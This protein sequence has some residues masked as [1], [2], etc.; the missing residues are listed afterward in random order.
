VN[1][2]GKA[3][4]MGFAFVEFTQHTHAVQCLTKLNNNPNIFTDDKVLL[5]DV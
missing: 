1:A 2:A 5:L 4:S 3:R